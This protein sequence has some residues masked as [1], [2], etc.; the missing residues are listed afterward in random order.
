MVL[1]NI[2][3]VI[4]VIDAHRQRFLPR[5]CSVII[6]PIGPPT[7]CYHFGHLGGYCIDQKPGEIDEKL[8]K[9]FGNI[10]HCS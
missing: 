1:F 5:H 4:L 9:T 2:D 6:Y 8:I 3:R 7:G 10:N